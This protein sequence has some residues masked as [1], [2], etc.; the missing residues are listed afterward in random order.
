MMF[1]L[2]FLGRKWYPFIP[3]SP[4]GIFLNAPENSTDEPFVFFFAIQTWETGN[5]DTKNPIILKNLDH[6]P[7]FSP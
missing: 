2:L 1:Q 3:S 4:N 5:V 6:Q 7:H